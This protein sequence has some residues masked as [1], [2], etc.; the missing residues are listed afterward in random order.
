MTKYWVNDATNQSDWIGT[1]WISLFLSL[2]GISKCC[3]EA[4]ASNLVTK[5][6]LNVQLCKGSNIL[7][8]WLPMYLNDTVLDHIS[9]KQNLQA[10][11]AL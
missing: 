6:R 10:V 5:L 11:L 4:V 8:V 7:E 9:N 2:W 1:E 3:P